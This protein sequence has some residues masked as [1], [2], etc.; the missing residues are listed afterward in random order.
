VLEP[1]SVRDGRAQAASR[2][3]GG[4]QGEQTVITF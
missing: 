1:V 4:I 3:P 2:L